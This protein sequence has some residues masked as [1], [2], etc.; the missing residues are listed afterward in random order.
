MAIHKL[1][2][3]EIDE[4]D[5]QLIAIHTSLEDYRLAYF[6]NQKLPILLGKS[7]N[8][9]QINNKEGVNHFSKY[10]FE[11]VENNRYWNLIQNKNEKTTLKNDNS[12]NLFANITLEVTTK[13]YFL[14][15]LKK[16]DYFLKIENSGL[17]MEAIISQLNTIEKITTLYEI[18]VLR[19]KSKHNLIF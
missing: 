16:V 17:E 3:D 2:I 18:D 7:K 19:I 8:A 5:F 4:V 14:Q 9:I 15:E 13:V 12:E 6:L 11:D 1:Y 10:L